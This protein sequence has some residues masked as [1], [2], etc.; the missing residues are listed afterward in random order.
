[1]IVS[2]QEKGPRVEQA[3]FLPLSIPI[4]LRNGVERERKVFFSA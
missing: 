2:D 3:F 4:V 1:M